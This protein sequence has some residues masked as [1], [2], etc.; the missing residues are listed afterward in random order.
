MRG[1]VPAAEAVALG[2]Q[3]LIEVAER[4]WRLRLLLL[5]R[6]SKLRFGQAAGVPA[7]FGF[8]GLVPVGP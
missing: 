2:G 8:P 5:E 7:A 1:G 4:S 6:R 3:V